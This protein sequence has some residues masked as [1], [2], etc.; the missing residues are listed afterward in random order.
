M[1]FQQAKNMLDCII[2]LETLIKVHK[3]LKK[4]FAAI[5]YDS[6]EYMVAAYILR[7]MELE[8]THLTHEEMP[9]NYEAYVTRQNVINFRTQ[10]GKM[11]S[12][13]KIMLS[14]LEEFND[15]PYLVCGALLNEKT[16]Q[17]NDRC[18]GIFWK[19]YQ[20]FDVDSYDLMNDGLWY[21]AEELANIDK[22]LAALECFV[23]ITNAKTKKRSIHFII[24]DIAKTTLVDFCKHVESAPE[25]EEEDDEVNISLEPLVVTSLT[26]DY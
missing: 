21:D 12:G 23:R 11:I 14:Y 5:K 25:E 15:D 20:N 1:N 18:S 8:N 2:L 4:V 17:E 3:C 10:V 6:D 7:T 13:F 19:C 16:C 26:I 24:R 9:D 22:A